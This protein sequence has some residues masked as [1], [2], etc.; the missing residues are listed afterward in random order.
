M[1]NFMPIQVHEHV[2]LHY[3]VPDH[4][5]VI[6]TFA[7][8]AARASAFPSSSVSLTQPKRLY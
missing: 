8:P 5:L 6:G 2:A 1:S 7:F 4:M 3:L